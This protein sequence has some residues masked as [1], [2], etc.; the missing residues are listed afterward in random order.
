MRDFD[1]Y[2]PTIRRRNGRRHGAF[3][4]I[5]LL[6]VMGI[7]AILV[8]II[9]GVAGYVMRSANAKDT[10]ATQAILMD[11]IQTWHDKDTNTPKRYPPTDPSGV[12]LIKC[13]LGNY[14]AGWPDATSPSVRAAKEVLQKL[15]K[16]AY[17]YYTD[18]VRD[19]WGVAMQ[20]SETGGLG[21]RPVIISAGADG[22][23]GTEDDIR[24]D[25]TQ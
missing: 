14:G 22:K 8:A 7:L 6:V 16:D 25:E 4:L 17:P 23:F 20:Y 13:L 2:N 24:S 18:P 12:A 15:S 9:A 10:A 19:A 11:A 5:E 1:R 21:G 3:T